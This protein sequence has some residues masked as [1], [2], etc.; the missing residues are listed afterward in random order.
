MSEEEGEES[1]DQAD[2]RSSS[3]EEAMEEQVVTRGHDDLV[4]GHIFDSQNAYE[5]IFNEFVTFY[6]KHRALLTTAQQ[7]SEWPLLTEETYRNLRPHHFAAYLEWQGAPRA[8]GHLGNQEATV[9]QKKGALS[10][11]MNNIVGTVDNWSSQHNTGNP[12]KR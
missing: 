1:L 6:N 5:A 9:S 7:E 10:S 11:L 8:Y 4:N 3:E 12:M 2:E